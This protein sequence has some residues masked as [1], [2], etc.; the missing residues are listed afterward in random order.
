VAWRKSL[1]RRRNGF[2]TDV[3]VVLFVIAAPVASFWFCPSSGYSL[4]P[5]P[6]PRGGQARLWFRGLAT[7]S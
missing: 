1:R 3:L 4:F 6:P 2:L 7:G 5:D